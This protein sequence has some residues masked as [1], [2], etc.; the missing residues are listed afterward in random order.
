MR[1]AI[2]QVWQET[3]TFN[4]I[5]TEL[6]HFEQNGLYVG[7][8]ILDRMQGIGELGGFLAAADGEPDDIEI[9][10]ILRAWAMSGGRI[11]AP[12]LDF[13]K[14][15]LVAGLREAGP[16]DGVF[17][18]LHGAAA[19][20]NEDDP[21]GYLLAAVRAVVGDDVP[22]VVSLDHHCNITR[23]L[24]G[25]V[26]A[27]VGY[28]TQPHDPFET[29]VRAA[30]LLFRT[31]RGEINPTVAWQKIPMLAPADR[32]AT[33]EWPMKAW[34]DAAREMEQRRGVLSVSTFPV[35]PW[36]DVAEVGWATVSV[37]DGDPSLAGELAADLANRAWAL[38]EAFWEIRRVPLAEGIRRA[39][40]AE[41]GPVVICDASDSVLSGAP[42][43]STRLLQEMLDQRIECVALLPIVDPDVVAEAIRAGVG[44][45][46]TVSLGGKRDTIFSRPLQV[47]GQVAGIATDG[48]SFPLGPWGQA[49]MGR[50]VL[51]QI[52]SIKLVV[53][54]QAGIGGTDPE[55]YR[56]FGVEPAEAQIVVVKTYYHYQPFRALMKDTFMIDYP[57]LSTWDLRLFP[58]ERAPRP[59][60]PLDEVPVW[61]ANA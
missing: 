32:G 10:P 15:R 3:N 61:E 1:I 23:R 30:K 9:V 6:Q 5:P 34:F 56:S 11:T 52:G 44:R 16:V 39:A 18:S 8:A 28:Q 49:S 26:D 48:L 31:V 7:D 19:A 41:A 43:D 42:G 25:L 35:Q 13:F 4:P 45:E 58:W 53:S 22:L 40:T 37:T 59:L 38:R 27:L 47:T 2:A 24:V 14:Q 21:Q 55:I 17:F 51:L 57:G 54:E 50:T 20:E 33:A 36:L 46:L 29:G 12:A 60:Y